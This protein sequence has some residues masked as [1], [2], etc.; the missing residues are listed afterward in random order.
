MEQAEFN[1]QA[2][3]A[4]EVTQV[5]VDYLKNQLKYLGFGED[6][7]LHKDLM[8]GIASQE[9]KFTIQTTSDKVMKG[10]SV[11]FDLEFN[12][13][14]QG[15]VFFNS[16]QGKLTN[17]K[18]EERTQNFNTAFGVTAKEAINLLE[19]RAVRKKMVSKENREPYFAFIKLNF[20]E[21]K[22]QYGNYNLEVYGRNYGVDVNSIMDKS[23]LVFKD[24]KEREYTKNHLEK[25]NITNV[26]FKK[27]NAEMKGFAVLNPQYKM[28][29]LYD[30]NMTRVN[31][32]KPLVREMESNEKSNALE[33]SQKRGI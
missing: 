9:D 1:Q 3:F 11:V 12:R 30:E 6:E 15:K 21:N 14:K 28:L 13:S 22:N 10:N 27:D 8:E 26:V 18:N 16:F 32:N 25:G 4:K 23:N 2:E 31:T 19:G 33:Y 5:D 17:R 20:N 7:K 29:N 24:A